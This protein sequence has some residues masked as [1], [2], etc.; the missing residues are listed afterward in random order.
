M[1]TPSLRTRRIGGVIGIVAALAMIPAYV[2]GSPEVPASTDEA[3]DYYEQAALFISANGWLPIV[4]LLGVIFLLGVLAAVFRAASPGSI[5]IRTAALVGGTVWITLTAAG[6]AAEV[7]YPAA[8]MRFP[9][10]A[11]AGF[12][13]PLTLTLASWLYHFCQV[14]AAALMI[15]TGILSYS[16]T[17]DGHRAFP[18]WFAFVS[19]AFAI[20]ALLH[21]WLPYSFWSALAGLGWL[22]IVS[23]LLFAAPKAAPAAA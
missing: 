3:A 5:A 23:L 2:V 13:A 1:D 8:L 17:P 11:D 15:G 21:T 22:L 20:F 9:E 4:H 14:G 10:L 12:L 16:A 7:A 18:K 19:F 6:W